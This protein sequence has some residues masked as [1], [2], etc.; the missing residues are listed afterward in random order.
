[1]ISI[2]N[3]QDCC[4][5]GACAQKCPKQCITMREDKEGFVYPSI[6]E[7]LCIDCNLCEKVCPILNAKA[8]S[9]RAAIHSV[10]VAYAKDH[11]IRM[12]SSSGGIFSKLAEKFMGGGTVY[13]AAFDDDHLVHHISIDQPKDLPLLRGSKYL[14][15]RTEHSF[16]DVEIDLKNGK[17]VFYSGTACQIAG[18][19]MFLGKDYD[20]LYTVNVL[21]HGTPSPKLWKKYLSELEKKYGSSVEQVLFRKKKYGW[22]NYS[23]SLLFADGTEYENVFF[24]DIYMQMFLKDIC[25]RP[26][27]HQC[28]FKGMDRPSDLTLGDCWGIQDHMP[29]MDDDKGTSVILVHTEKGQKWLD[30]IS[31][32]LEI[33]SSDLDS[34]LPISADSRKS[35]V[36]HPKREVFF[37]L[38]AND[39]PFTK[40]A[41]LLKPTLSVRIK[42]LLRR[43]KH[44]LLH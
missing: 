2:I 8:H 7:E 38:L 23:V 13:G 28:R 43:V 5:C 32:E 44:K 31:S 33:V 15:S 14:Q 30:L 34:V 11:D 21:C 40:L 35:V 20:N 25:L 16:A 6:N 1:M 26:S 42:G 29:E 39:A 22:K 10:Y 37:D 27:C 4:G 18:L 12:N 36:P 3:K 41:A 24:K 9:G 17:S 19:K